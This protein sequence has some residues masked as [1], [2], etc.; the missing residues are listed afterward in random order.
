MNNLLFFI[1]EWVAVFVGAFI[2][3]LIYYYW[4]EK[5]GKKTILKLYLAH[6]FDSRHKMR[7]WELRT[8]FKYGIEIINPFF[9][10]ER[11]DEV[12]IEDKGSTLTSQ[13]TRTERYG[14]TDDDVTEL[15]ER[16]LNLIRSCLGIIAIV[17]GSL[18]YGTIQEMVY[19]YNEKKLV[20]SVISNGHAGHP[21]LRYHSS[22][23]FRDLDELEAELR[24]VVEK[25]L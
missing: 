1:I 5:R 25:C 13:A 20:L 12:V 18:S 16:D 3:I 11:P 17:D 14:L 23:V 19:A 8:E 21:W 22:Q 15:V 6:P 10:V 2:G 7:E 4:Y 9:D 24:D